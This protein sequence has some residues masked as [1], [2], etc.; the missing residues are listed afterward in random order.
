MSLSALLVTALG[1]AVIPAAAQAA[2]HEPSAGNGRY[3][4]GLAAP[5][6]TMGAL[7]AHADPDP[8]PDPVPPYTERVSTTTTGEQLAD[9]SYDPAM[10]DRRV[11]AFTSDGGA[12][13]LSGVSVLDSGGLSSVNYGANGPSYGG[14]PCASGRMVGFVSESTTLGS[15]PKPDHRPTVYIRNRAVGKITGL[16]SYQGVRFTSMGQ[17]HV[18][19]G[20]QWVVYTATLPATDADPTPQPRVYRFKFNGGTTDLV[21]EASAEAADAPSISSQGEYVSYKQGGDIYVRN[22]TTGALEKV[23]VALNGGAANG[24]SSGASLS[25][26]GRR[27]A[28]ESRASNLASGDKNRDTNVFVR[29]L[30]AGTTTLV[31]A[32]KKKGYTAQASLSKNGTHVAY[33]S[34]KNRGKGSVPS[35]YLRELATGT[36]QLISADLNGGR[37]DLAAQHPSVNDDGT[38]VAFESKSA[39]LVPGDTNGVSDIFL[40]T[41]PGVPQP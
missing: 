23:S 20:C 38:V 35:V 16:H 41:V 30:D 33:I 9:P 25:Y 1:T 6:G 8:D 15:P 26:D 3:V 40:R 28:F 4:P 21:S 2:P 12:D 31:K 32:P 36:T 39:D 5:L 37:N 27:V 24:P 11:V 34:A 14:A 17:P 22:M 19:P 18:D 7:P 13:G 10:G 29:D